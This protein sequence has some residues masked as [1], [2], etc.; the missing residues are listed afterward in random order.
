MEWGIICAVATVLFSFGAAAVAAG[1]IW[2]KAEERFDGLDDL[3][4]GL[5]VVLSRIEAGKAAGC[6]EHAG[7][8]GKLD[9]DVSRHQEWLA[10]QGERL[11]DHERRIT[12]IETV[13]E[14]G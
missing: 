7:R 4:E 6:V 9:A 2:G 5:K 11:Q 8:L 10:D 14:E 12:K 3:V 13:L 1:Y